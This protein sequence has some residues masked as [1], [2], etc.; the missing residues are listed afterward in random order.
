MTNT[1]SVLFSQHSYFH[2]I[3]CAITYKYSN[4]V[5]KCYL[6]TG[7][8]LALKNV[9]PKINQFQISGAIVYVKVSEKLR[10]LEQQNM[11]QM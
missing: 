3:T 2:C 8:A 1:I 11:P 9:E 10:N 4:F 6:F 7:L 5:Y